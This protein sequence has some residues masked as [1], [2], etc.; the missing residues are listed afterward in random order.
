MVS[1]QWQEGLLDFCSLESARDHLE[2]VL[3]RCGDC[4]PESAA[5]TRHEQEMAMP[6]RCGRDA[7]EGAEREVK[8]AGMPCALG[9]AVADLDH[10]ALIGARSIRSLT[11]PVKRTLPR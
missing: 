4:G 11:E 9:I 5:R 2:T 1:G 10:V 7:R 8:G 3:S 6:T